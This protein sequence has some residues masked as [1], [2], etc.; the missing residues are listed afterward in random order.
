[1]LGAT[2]STFVM[3]NVDSWVD[4]TRAM[5]TV[6][7]AIG[8]NLWL[9]PGELFV[10]PLAITIPSSGS[11]GLASRYPAIINVFGQ[12]TNLASIAVSLWDLSHQHSA[13]LDILLVSPSGT[14]IMLMSHAGSTNAVSHA[15][16]VFQQWQPLPPE[17]GPIPS[18]LTTSY[19]PSNYA[20]TN[21]LP[22]APPGP[23][24]SSLDDLWGTNPNGVWR[25][26]IYDDKQGGLGQ[27][28]GSWDLVLGFQ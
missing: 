14:N 16:I 6:T 13:D 26:Y 23:Y 19:S 28:A 3:T 11:S 8:E 15:N 2:N 27:L 18:A 1:M 9:G 4:G 24:S 10:A 17:S 20:Q 12:P 25:M 5:V 7:N 22:N 21:S